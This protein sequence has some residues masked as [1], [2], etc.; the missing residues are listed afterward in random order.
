MGAKGL[1]NTYRNFF[2]R[3]ARH[4]HSDSPEVWTGRMQQAGFQVDRW[5]HYY[6][7]EALRV[8]EWGHLWGLPSLVAKRLTGRWILSPT[9]WNLALTERVTR[10]HYEAPAE[11]AQGVCSFYIARRTPA[12]PLQG[13]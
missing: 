9:H 13:D 4:H 12:P 1:A 7:P 10:K 6:P 8:T 2:N 5:W 11:S 3:I